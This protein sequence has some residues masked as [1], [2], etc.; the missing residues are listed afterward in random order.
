MN[1]LVLLHLQFIWNLLTFM[2]A[3]Y[4]GDKLWLKQ[5]FLK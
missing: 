2:Y 3:L 4:D 1:F 5:V